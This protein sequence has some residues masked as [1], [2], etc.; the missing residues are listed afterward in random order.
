[1]STTINPI[2]PHV[3]T[4]KFR[5]LIERSGGC[6]LWPGSPHTAGYVTL[7]GKTGRTIFAHR[8]SYAIFKGEPGDLVVHHKCRNRLCV[9]PEHLE[10][11]TITENVMATDSQSF[12]AV[13]SR[14]T[15]CPK[16]HEYDRQ[17]TIVSH[18]K[19]G[20]AYRRCR[21]CQAVRDTGR[22]R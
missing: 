17:N 12:A 1:M 8:A 16:G 2:L 11:R 15:A 19:D 14:K 10:T 20:S 18:R 5:L 22:T 3:D 7:R 4:T 21:A 13:N 9:N 6:W